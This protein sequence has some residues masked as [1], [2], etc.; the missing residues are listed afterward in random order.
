MASIKQCKMLCAR[1]Q[2][3]GMEYDFDSFKDLENGEVDDK[4]KEIEAFAEKQ[5][6]EAAKAKGRPAEKSASNQT[7][8]EKG[9]SK[10]IGAP[11]K[12]IND[13]RFG[14]CCKLTIQDK[15]IEWCLEHK[16][17][18]EELVVE[19]YNTVA[20][21]ESALSAPSPLTYFRKPDGEWVCYDCKEGVY[22]GMI[23]SCGA[24]H[25][26][27]PSEAETAKGAA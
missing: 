12:H 17:D 20:G 2:E 6:E 15:G 10:N 22:P 13:V 25:S 26:L 18:F 5:K 21:A 27:P 8:Q 4:I 3:A 19:L 23:C 14:M 1:S 11:H 16:A 9:S 24:K 7:K